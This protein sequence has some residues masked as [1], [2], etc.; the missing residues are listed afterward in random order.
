MHISFPHSP[1]LQ[2]IVQLKV[3]HTTVKQS[4]EIANSTTFWERF[5]SM[6]TNPVNRRALGN[7]ISLVSRIHINHSQ[8]SGVACKPFSSC[9]GS[10]HSCTIPLHF[11]RRSNLISLLRSASS[12]PARTSC[13]RCLP[14][15]EC[16]YSRLL[17]TQ[18]YAASPP[19]QIH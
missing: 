2:R 18:S 13:S 3:L 11:S 6:S 17:L 4:I 8:L 16:F 5:I 15:S 9:V 14:S 19:T 1:S 10:I 7:V 12:F